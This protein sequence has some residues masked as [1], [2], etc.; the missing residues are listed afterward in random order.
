MQSFLLALPLR[1]EADPLVFI[2]QIC[3]IVQA[4]N[5]FPPR[6]FQF[7]RCNWFPIHRNRQEVVPFLPLLLHLVPASVRVTSGFV[8]FPRHC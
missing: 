7:Q 8:W 6:S 5:V 4:E 3:S 1:E 2:A